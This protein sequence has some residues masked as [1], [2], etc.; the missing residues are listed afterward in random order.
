MRGYA[1]VELVATAR[2]GGTTSSS[3]DGRGARH[4][5]VKAPS[6]RKGCSGEMR[7]T[8]RTARSLSRSAELREKAHRLIPAGA[9]TYSKGDDQF[10]A[11]A[12][13]F[14]ER[15]RGSRVW[16]VDGNEYLDWGMGL[17]S[18]I[19]GHAYQAVLDAVRAELDRGSNFVRPSPI[20]VKLAE[21]L[22]TLIPSAEMVKFAKNGSDVTTA[23]VRL[24]RAATGRD[25]VAIC[26]D[27]PFF[28]IDDWFIGT[29]PA[30]SG[31]P[32]AFK[33]L[34]LTFRYNDLATLSRLFDAYPGQ[35][36]AVILEP[37]NF[38][39]PRGGF[40]QGV[41]KLC[42]SNGALMILDEI[43]TGFRFGVGGAQAR[44]GVTPD[45]S[46]FGKSLGNGFSISAVVGRRDVMELGGLHHSKP[47]VFL[48]STTNGGET[49]SIAASI[50]TLTELESKDVPSH[51]DRIGRALTQGVDS[52][53]SELGIHEHVH[54]I[55][56]PCSPHMMFFDKD[57]QSSNELRTLFAQEMIEAGVL[58]GY[59]AP[60]FSHSA[61][62]VDET[63]SAARRA[64]PI[65]REAIDRGV[66]GL[67]RGPAVKPVFRRFN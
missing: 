50:A 59:F 66:A 13:G 42:T 53:A 7:L 64:L 56:E 31:I 38:V 3:S 32:E 25:Y 27:N 62:D 57:G 45:L 23:A 46:T 21:R 39:A 2:R 52:L 49:H 43:I 47:R 15:G 55:G 11:N 18:V 34:S 58:A 12:P 24:A 60:S 17:R 37:M 26:A 4:R 54:F 29:T 51:L 44:F 33:R 8:T 5:W 61:G 9:H 35:I 65:V 1:E 30:D 22:A 48:L 41:R 16:D 36:A 28:S 6:N 10:P 40:L 19:L 14:I 67:L 63:L 20:E